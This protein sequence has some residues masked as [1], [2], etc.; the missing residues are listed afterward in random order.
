MTNALPAPTDVIPHRDPFLFLDEVTELEPGVSARGFWIPGEDL[1]FF[2][3]HFPGRPTLPGVLMAES[4]AQLGAYAVL[5]GESFAGKIPL[6]GGLDKAKF[7]RQVLPGD[8]L[9]LE[10]TVTR[11]SARAGKASGRALVNGEVACSC[12]LLFVGVD[13]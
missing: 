1:P 5:H 11:M 8:R 10:L 7:R 13:I 2:A 12:D 6:F 3:G 4:I 9:D